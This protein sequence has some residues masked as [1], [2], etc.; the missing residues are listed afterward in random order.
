MEEEGGKKTE[1]DTHILLHLQDWDEEKFLVM[2]SVEELWI[3][4]H[5]PLSTWTERS[6]FQNMKL[7]KP[8]KNFKSI[9]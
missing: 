3:E 1:I 7:T 6:F 9:P 8:T 2:V 4:K 5:L